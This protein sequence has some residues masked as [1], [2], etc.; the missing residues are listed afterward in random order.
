[1]SAKNTKNL[2]FGAVLNF[3]WNFQGFGG[4]KNV[5]LPSLVGELPSCEAVSCGGY[6]SCVV[7]S[8]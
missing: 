3:K 2:D 5:T 4:K 7:T 1:M 8:T 6:H